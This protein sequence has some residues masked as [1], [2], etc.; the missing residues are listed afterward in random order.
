M[1]DAPRNYGFGCVGILNRESVPEVGEEHLP[2]V[3]EYVDELQKNLLTGIVEVVLEEKECINLK[4]G[5]KFRVSL[6]DMV[7]L[8]EVGGK[9]GMGCDDMLS[10]YFELTSNMRERLMKEVSGK[11]LLMDDI[12]H[13]TD[14]EEVG[15]IW[16]SGGEL[17]FYSADKEQEFYRQNMGLGFRYGMCGLQDYYDQLNLSET[18]SV[19]S[20]RK[21]IDNIKDYDYYHWADE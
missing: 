20:I 10:K 3:G 7:N 8:V 2:N 19:E 6:K 13:T 15:V 17:I 16:V 4:G 21:A 1:Y 9:H 18:N 11:I 12:Y 5:A 14:S